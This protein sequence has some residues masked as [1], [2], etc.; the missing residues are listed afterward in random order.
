MR[1]L[2]GISLIVIFFLSVLSCKQAQEE[3]VSKKEEKVVEKVKEQPK[4]RYVNRMKVDSKDASLKLVVG[5]ENV[6]SIDMKNNIP[7]RGVQFVL[8]GVNITAVNT[9]ARTKGYL[10]T[11]NKESGAVMLVDTSGGEIEPGTGP[12]AEIECDKSG[13][14]DLLEIKI[15]K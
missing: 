9:T 4:G 10:A 6:H 1:Y 14:P 5:L 8:K 3:P 12:I 13:S 7:I 2:F 15:A 11:F